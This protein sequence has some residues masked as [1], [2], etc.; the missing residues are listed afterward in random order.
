MTW[1]VQ[2]ASGIAAWAARSTA[3][4]LG[5]QLVPSDGSTS[6]AEPTP[7]RSRG[8][9][10]TG[11]LGTAGNLRDMPP[12]PATDAGR[13]STPTTTAGLSNAARSVAPTGSRAAFLELL[14]GIERV[15]VFEMCSGL[16]DDVMLACDE[17]HDD[18]LDAIDAVRMGERR[19]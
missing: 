16:P 18:V 7:H 12:V 15:L 14:M 11:A 3:S 10:S 5:Y 19:A 17:L 4:A 13:R 2:R 8:C 6:K 9:T 1:L